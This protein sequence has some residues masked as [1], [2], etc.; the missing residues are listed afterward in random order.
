[1]PKYVLQRIDDK[2]YVAPSGSRQSYTSNIL[3]ARTF[4]SREQAQG[5]ACGNEYVVEVN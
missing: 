1:M 2:K 4:S 3:K 5:E